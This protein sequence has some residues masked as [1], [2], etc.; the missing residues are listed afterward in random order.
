MKVLMTADAVGGVWTY[1]L[2]LVEGLAEH[3]VEVVLALL[4]PAPTAEQRREL[5]RSSLAGWAHRGFALEWMGDAEEDLERTGWWLLE[6]CDAARPDLLHLNGYGVAATP[7][8]V[9]KL[10]VGH[11]CVLS[12][13]EAV[14]GRPAG[15]EWSWYRRA[16]VRGLGRADALVAPTAAMLDELVRL[17][18]PDCP[19]EVIPNGLGRGPRPL[20]KE[21]LVLGVGRVW[22]AGKNL[23]ALRR[24]AHDLPWPVVV[25]GAG[26]ELGRISPERLAELYGRAAIF[27]APA[28]YEPFGLSALEAGLA[29]CALVLGDIPSLREV[30]GEAALFVDPSDD[31]A[32]GATLRA[33]IR[34]PAAVKALGAAARARA[35]RYTRELMTAGYL[36]L[37]ERLLT[38]VAEPAPQLEVAR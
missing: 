34:A 27:A 20:A 37:Y 14:R 22:D 36:D 5:A 18:A 15:P 28:R 10:V 1:A 19:R 23:D 29:R 31:E 35:L 9:P 17:Y 4:G 3:D 12:W 8:P 24:V 26:G 38:E 33:L 30:W 7:T 16:V 6:L 13:H 11:S 25:A 32:L 2:D 21:E